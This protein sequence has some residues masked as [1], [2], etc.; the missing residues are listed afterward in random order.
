M[1][2]QNYSKWSFYGWLAAIAVGITG[3]WLL[4][5]SQINLKRGD[6]NE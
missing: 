4:K 2:E 1:A 3:E 5:P 6:K